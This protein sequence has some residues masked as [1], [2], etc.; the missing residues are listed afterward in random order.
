MWSTGA[1]GLSIKVAPVET[2]T[3]TVTV[4]DRDGCTAVDQVTVEVRRARCDETDVYLP[5]A[6]TPNGDGNND[7]LFVRSNFIDEMEL[8]IYNRWGQQVFRTTDQSVGW[9]GT[10]EGK[11]LP[12]D[13]YA[14]Y[15]RVICV[16]AVEYRKKG[17]VNLIR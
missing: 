13:A 3:Y 2:T 5:N 14:Y 4:T 10:F 16:N 6:F 1:T 9:D 12:P 7:R 17:N 8:I 11:E 15:L